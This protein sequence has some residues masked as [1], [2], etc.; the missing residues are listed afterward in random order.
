M[1]EYIEGFVC[2]ECGKHSANPADLEFGY[3]G[4]CHAYTGAAAATIAWGGDLPQYRLNA[5][6]LMRCCT[7]ALRAWIALHQ[8]PW[9][10]GLRV[11]C[12]HHESSPSFMEFDG[13]KWAWAKTEEQEESS[14]RPEN[15]RCPAC[16]SLGLEVEEVL[17]ARQPGTYSLAGMQAKVSARSVVNWRCKR[18]GAS[19][20]AG[21]DAA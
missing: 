9:E 8:G 13:E 10:A 11:K 15:T 19:G 2:P 16:G 21:P 12:P 7:G 18:C 4:A 1:D 3:C 5:G 17:V 6:G 20:P 14:L